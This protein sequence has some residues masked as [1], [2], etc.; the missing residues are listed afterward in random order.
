MFCIHSSTEERPL[1]E[2]LSTWRSI[3]QSNQSIILSAFCLQKVW[4]ANLTIID[5]AEMMQ[6]YA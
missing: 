5:F 6:P 1:A 2:Y 3:N 4:S